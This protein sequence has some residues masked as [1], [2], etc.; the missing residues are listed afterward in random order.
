MSRPNQQK[1]NNPRCRPSIKPLSRPL[2]SPTIYLD[3]L[4]GPSP[5]SC[6]FRQ[7]GAQGEAE[8]V[9]DYNITCNIIIYYNTGVCKINTRP[10]R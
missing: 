4:S 9:G 2:A 5:R 3:P 7:T 8:R 6:S 1:H 10:K